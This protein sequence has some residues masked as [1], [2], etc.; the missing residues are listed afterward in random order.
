MVG[1]DKAREAVLACERSLLLPVSLLRCPCSSWPAFVFDHDL[2]FG[3][4]G[5]EVPIAGIKHDRDRSLARL[6][7]P[8]PPLISPPRCIVDRNTFTEYAEESALG[9]YT[10]GRGW[11][12]W[13]KVDGVVQRGRDSEDDLFAM[14]YLAASGRDLHPV[15]LFGVVLMLSDGLDGRV[16]LHAPLW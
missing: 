11:Q 9:Q 8:A 15:H 3:S 1:G 6:P 7:C 10:A 16:E 5:V 2:A 14:I 4:V 13:I 12:G